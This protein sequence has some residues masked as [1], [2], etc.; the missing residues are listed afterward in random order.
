MAK[1]KSGSGWKVVGSV[2]CGLILLAGGA[3]G[4][5][6]LANHINNNQ[7]V[8]EEVVEETPEVIESQSVEES[9]AN[10][11]FNELYEQYV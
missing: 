4:G 7:V 10:A 2:A 9:I 1:Q 11:T 5:Y 3:V 8:E 6:Y